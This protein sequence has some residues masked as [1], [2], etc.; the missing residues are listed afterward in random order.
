M[1]A[2]PLLRLSGFWPSSIP[3]GNKRH[4]QRVDLGEVEAEMIGDERA[5]GGAIG[6]REGPRLLSLTDRR[7]AIRHADAT[8]R[9]EAISRLTKG[10]AGCVAV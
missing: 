9:R 8:V 6:E 2:R 5:Q 1:T 7:V 4:A 10:E 3:L